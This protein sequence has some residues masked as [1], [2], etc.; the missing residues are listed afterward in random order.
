MEKRKLNERVYAKFENF[1]KLV[2]QGLDFND[3]LMKRKEFWDIKA[4]STWHEIVNVPANCTNLSKEVFDIER[5]PP[6]AYYD[7]QP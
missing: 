3:N 5:F 7:A 4:A 2:L 6:E 1:Q